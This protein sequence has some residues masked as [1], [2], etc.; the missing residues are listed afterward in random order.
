MN[1]AQ[2]H[3]LRLAASLKLTA[4][5]IASLGWVVEAAASTPESHFGPPLSFIGKAKS[6]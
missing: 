6:A 2:Q 4:E 1:L 5:C 3:L